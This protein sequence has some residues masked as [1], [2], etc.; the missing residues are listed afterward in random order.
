MNHPEPRAERPAH[1]LADHRWGRDLGHT[2]DGGDADHDHDDL[3]P[4]GPPEESA[5]WVQDHVSLH[6]VGI[7]ISSAGTQVIFSRL[8]LRRPGEDLTSR[9]FVVSR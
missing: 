7:D 6:S 8:H 2:H 1:T 3:G 5:L 9:Y 4:E